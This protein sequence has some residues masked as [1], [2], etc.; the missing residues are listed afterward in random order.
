[1]N[2]YWDSDAFLSYMNEVPERVFVLESILEDNAT[3]AVTL[4]TST[5][6]QVEVAFADTEKKQR[7]LSSEI[8]RRIDGFWA[9]VVCIDFDETIGRLARDL[10]RHAVA[11][12]W[13]L[14][15]LDAT[16]LATA[17][18]LSNS[19][20]VVD[21]FHTYDERLLKYQAFVSF[22]ICKPYIEQLE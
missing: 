4:Y 12:G 15:P 21:E 19:G 22:K 11:R 1:M 7:T 16:H 20:L 5:V 17:Q 14:K 9:S 13:S 2:I 10:M 6:S 3:G 8:E 18:W